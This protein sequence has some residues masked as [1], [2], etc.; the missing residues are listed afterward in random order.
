M[1]SSRQALQNNGK[2]FF[3]ISIS[4]SNYWPKTKKY[5]DRVNIDR[6]SMY[7]ISMDLT[8]QALQTNGKLLSNLRI[9]FRISYNF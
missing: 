8:R 7:C 1:D 5:S 2:F 3:H 9:I 6:S 4:F